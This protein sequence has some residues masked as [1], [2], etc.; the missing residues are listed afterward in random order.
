MLTIRTRLPF[1]V[2]LQR[3]TRKPFTFSNGLHVPAGYTIHSAAE[4]LQTDS[5]HHGEHA[6]EF[7]PWRWA[8]IRQDDAESLRHQ[9][10]A[11]GSTLLHFGHGKHACP[12]RF[13][14]D[15]SAWIAIARMLAV[16]SISKPLDANG[17][18]IE[19]NMTFMSGLNRWVLFLLYRSCRWMVGES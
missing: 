8:D 6:A 12:G 7:D 16:F 4:M 3:W 15:A 2:S 19:Q 1:I 17:K 9:M 13:F 18:Q 11:T 14:A 10:V 5:V